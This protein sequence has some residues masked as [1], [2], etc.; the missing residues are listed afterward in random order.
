MAMMNAAH[1]QACLLLGPL[2]GC[3]KIQDPMPKKLLTAIIVEDD[4]DVADVLKAYAQLA[5]LS[6]IGTARDGKSGLTVIN[7][8]LPDIVLLDLS[9]PIVS[10]FDLAVRVHHE[11]PLVNLIAITGHTQS[12]FVSRALRSGVQAVLFKTEPIHE[13]LPLAIKRLVKGHRYLGPCATDFLVEQV[14]AIPHQRKHHD[15][16]PQQKRVLQLIVHGFAI[17]Q[18]ASELRISEKGVDKHIAKMKL[19]LGIS[20]RADLIKWAI[21]KGIGPT[22]PH[23]VSDN[24][25]LPIS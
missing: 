17:K 18:I 16:T 12:D 25:T 7:K 21:G 1:Q 20:G 19:R 4:P 14:I 13:Q 3:R 15:L 23:Q 8:L 5:N 10:G 24:N 2:L 11:H 6:V 9:L 22:S